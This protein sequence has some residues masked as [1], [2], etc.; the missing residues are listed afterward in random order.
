MNTALLTRKEIEQRTGLNPRYI[1][2]NEV[3]IGL[4]KC[5]LRLPG[6]AKYDNAKFRFW[7]KA[8]GFTDDLV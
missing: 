6:I 8:Q 5:R 2:R 3:R 1:S 7:M 4:D